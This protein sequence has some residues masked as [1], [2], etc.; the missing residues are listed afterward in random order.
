M[1]LDIKT[2]DI[3]TNDIIWGVL[4]SDHECEQMWIECGTSEY[5]DEETQKVKEYI[6]Q[7]R[8]DI[9]ITMDFCP[10]ISKACHEKEI[11]YAAWLYDAPVQA[12]FHEEAYRDTNYFFVFDKYL[13]NYMKKLGI[14][15]VYYLPLA[16]NVTRMG[17]MEI[18][19]MDMEKYSCDVSFVGSEYS[20]DRY[21]YYRNGLDEKLGKEL[22]SYFE[23]MYG[24]WDGIDRV[25]GVLSDEVID[26]LSQ[27]ISDKASFAQNGI[28]ERVYFEEEVV[29]KA[30]AY[31]ERKD[32][33]STLADLKPRWYGANTESTDRIKDISYMPRLSYEEELPK[34]NNL[35]KINLSTT[36]HSISS[37][38]SMRVFDTIGA[39]GFIITNYQPEA[40]ELFEI[41][42]ELI[43][44]HDLD[45]L[46][47]LVHY[48][49]KH[50]KERVRVLKS[51]YDKVC[52][53]YTYPVAIQKILGKVF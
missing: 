34:A 10:T 35:T 2:K 40:E 47:E 16:A 36:L 24:K 32:M 27:M 50:D 4:E 5:D 1:C 12:I 28:P 37:G 45:E 29:P 7:I 43:V 51:G 3:Q 30:I 42:K 39:G 15:K 48:Y 33:I 20:F 44:Y 46:K 8:A 9:V 38:V 31:R 23:D 49:L 53:A 25:H 41:G 26:A 13:L 14:E 6:D 52:S 11:P 19:G 18:N 17:M 22:D 21:D